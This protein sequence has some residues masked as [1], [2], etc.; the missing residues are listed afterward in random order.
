MSNASEPMSPGE[1][2][3]IQRE[4]HLCFACTHASVCKVAAAI[5]PELLVIIQQCLAFENICA[6][7]PAR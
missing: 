7:A 1:L 4:C 5:D 3:A 6:K 2:K